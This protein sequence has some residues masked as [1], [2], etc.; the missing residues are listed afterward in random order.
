MDLAPRVYQPI[1][2]SGHTVHPVLTFTMPPRQHKS[3]VVIAAKARAK[4]KAAEKVAAE[5]IR[6]I[7]EEDQ[8]EKRLMTADPVAML[9]HKHGTKFRNMMNYRQSDK[10]L[11]AFL[12]NNEHLS[13]FAST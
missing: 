7:A 6:V 1:V 12:I 11:K 8:I 3:L 5:R 10:C 4:A 9:L 13:T 2:H